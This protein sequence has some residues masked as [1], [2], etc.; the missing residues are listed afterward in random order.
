MAD[1]YHRIGI[2]CRHRCLLKLATKKVPV[3]AG[4]MVTFMGAYKCMVNYESSNGSL[5]YLR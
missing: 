5:L 4:C 3:F 1:N 2:I